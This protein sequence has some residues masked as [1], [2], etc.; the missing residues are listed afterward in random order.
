MR[1]AVVEDVQALR[2]LDEERREVADV[3]D[4]VALDRILQLSSAFPPV[5]RAAGCFVVHRRDL[6]LP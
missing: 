5:L 1:P 6:L 2:A 3:A 4:H